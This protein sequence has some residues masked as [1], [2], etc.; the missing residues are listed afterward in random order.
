LRNI[1]DAAP[2]EPVHQGRTQSHAAKLQLYLFAMMCAATV[3]RDAR[4]VEPVRR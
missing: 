2:L 4:Q 1:N 3:R